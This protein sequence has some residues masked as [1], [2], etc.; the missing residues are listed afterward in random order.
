MSES[1]EQVVQL[2]I[3]LLDSSPFQG[4]TIS[5]T[6]DENDARTEKAL[7][8]LAA[9]I[10]ADGAILQPIIVRKNKERYE[11]V[12]G[13]RR[14]IACRRLAYT[15]IPAIVRKYDDNHAYLNT[16]LA[17]LQRQNL[18]TLELAR[19]FHQ[20][21][22]YKI[23]KDQRALAK[24]FCMDESHISEIINAL[25]LD[26]RIINALDKKDGITDMVILKAI[27][28]HDKVDKN[29][30]STSSGSCTGRSSTRRCRGT[31]R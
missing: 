31:R 18:S 19:V 23:C 15:S 5:E 13:H 26:T 10:K 11:V 9:T 22:A 1:N 14:V 28:R 2:D 8:E 3:A 21:I 25:K 27:R 17:N 6:P 7:V 20:M 16:I 24:V 30:K 12:D 29:G 4:R